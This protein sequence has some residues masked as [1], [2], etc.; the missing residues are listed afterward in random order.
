L[1]RAGN[2]GTCESRREMRCKE[3]PVV[4]DEKPNKKEKKGQ[5]GRKPGVQIFTM[6]GGKKRQQGIRQAK[7]TCMTGV[8]REKKK[9][10]AVM[11]NLER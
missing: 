3:L 9:R 7:V 4:Y 10:T 6:G 2:K 5:N 1:Q 8:E 11:E